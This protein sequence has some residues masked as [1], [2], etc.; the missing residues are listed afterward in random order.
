MGTSDVKVIIEQV[1]QLLAQEELTE[2][3]ELAI[4]KL[5]NVVEALSADKKSLA[6]EVE[7]L[8]K[9]LELKKKSKTT[10]SK[11]DKNTPRDDDNANSD[12]SSEKRRK[13]KKKP[14]AND[15]RSFK[16]LTIHDTVE[17]PVDP[18][19]LPH[20]AVRFQDE[21]VVVQDI[22]IK[23][24]NTQFQRHV[25]YSVSQQKY[26][27]GPLPAGYDH[28]DFGAS[29]RAVIVSLKYCGN[30]SEPKIGE[31]LENF[32][33]QVS[34]GSLSNIL[35]RSSNLFEQEYDDLL[36]AGLL[37]TPYQQ[38]D[39]TSARV[40]GEFWNTHILCNP[41]YT[42]YS[43]R[44]GKDRLTVL[45]VLQNTDE[46]RFRFDA[47]TC[48]LLQDEFSLSRKWSEEVAALGKVEVG[49][50]SLK[51]LLDGW[52]GQ[53]NQQVRKA[54]EHAA[55]IVF[56]RQQRSIPVVQTLVCDD[57]GQ[58]K[59]LTDKLSLCWIHAGR[60]YEKLSPIVDRHAKSLDSFLDRYWAYYAS[61]Q[62][63]RAGPTEELAEKL[64]LEFDELFSTQTKY[65]ALDDRI[66]KTAAMKD[67]LLTV[68]SVPEVPLHNN[69]S[70]LGARVSARRRDV[71]LHSRSE[72]G[73]RAMDIFTTLVQ[74]CKK[75]GISAFAYLRD[76]LSGSH[77][78]PSLARSIQIAAQCAAASG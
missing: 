35:T 62:D 36:I 13:S 72:R 37:S 40:K 73:V 48:Q 28:G 44:P 9:Q 22:Q 5:L 1:E 49:E 50:S 11:D 3:A 8:R 43:T 64:R 53:R 16:D 52:F 60:H 63:Y 58:F 10:G 24:K 47:V 30:M 69:G 31:F 74:T 7:R 27:R 18:D 71:S 19:T 33:V 45:K 34:S 70:E 17:C 26:Y 29:L 15:R 54:I 67:E 46:L 14:K 12:H 41:F 42:F 51:L 6:D 65:A 38:T 75:L 4:H 76:R 68:L 32:D 56:Y 66:A 23:P 25:F 77:E 78:M 20:D 55:A 61:L 57:A 21:I 39:D 59:L 2:R